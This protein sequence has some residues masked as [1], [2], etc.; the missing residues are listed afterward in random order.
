MKKSILMSGIL[1]AS[2]ATGAAAKE[3]A[4]FGKE[5][6]TTE[7]FKKAIQGLGP[8]SEMVKTNPRIQT[9]FLNHMIDNALLSDEAKKSEV[10][11]VC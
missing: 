10:R 7:E 6:I 5:K 2:I 1:V 4:S 3:V 8:Q 11:Q 9:Q